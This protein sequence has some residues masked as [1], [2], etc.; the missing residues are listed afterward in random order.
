MARR[1]GRSDR[2]SDTDPSLVRGL[3]VTANSYTLI[4]VPAASPNHRPFLPAAGMSA[5]CDDD[6][7]TFQSVQ[8]AEA[9]LFFSR[10]GCHLPS[11]QFGEVCT[12]F[13]VSP[14]R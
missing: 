4:P 7:L 3:S 10:V 13:S 5:P 1:S 6:G 9:V 12:F 11:A 14:D 2:G 8:V